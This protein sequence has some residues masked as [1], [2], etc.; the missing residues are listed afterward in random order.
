MTWLSSR[1]THFHE[2][3]QIYDVKMRKR[4]K[5]FPTTTRNERKCENAL[6]NFY[7][8]TIFDSYIKELWKC[9]FGCIWIS[10]WLLFAN[11]FYVNWFVF[12]QKCWK[13]LRRTSRSTFPRMTILAQQWTNLVEDDKMKQLWVIKNAW[14][15]IQQT[16]TYNTFDTHSPFRMNLPLIFFNTISEQQNVQ[17]KNLHLKNL[18]WLEISIEFSIIVAW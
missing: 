10:S 6:V 11:N 5:V 15:F 18:H 4:K 8:A 12:N 9:R 16:H 7:E 13:N 14:F 3:V 1:L 17:E 2:K